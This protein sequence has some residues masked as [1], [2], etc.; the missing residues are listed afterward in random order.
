MLFPGD[1]YECAQT[2]MYDNSNNPDAPYEVRE[3]LDNLKA[4]AERLI[5]LSDAYDMIL[6]NHNG[7]PIAKEYLRHYVELVDAV[8]AG[9]AV[10]EDKLNHPFIEMDPKAPTLCRV[11]HKDVSIFIKKDLVMS[12]YGSNSEG[13]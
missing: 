4:N 11:R 2:L 6:P 12:V 5:G 7:W 8:Y 1:E 3:R 9:E 10:V 13:I